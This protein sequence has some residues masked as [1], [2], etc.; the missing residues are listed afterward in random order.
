MDRRGESAGN[1][2]DPAPEKQHTGRKRPVRLCIKAQDVHGLPAG[3][4]GHDDD[5][6]AGRVRLCLLH[7]AVGRMSSVGGGDPVWDTGAV[8]DGGGH[9]SSGGTSGAGVC[10][11]VSLGGR[12]QSDALCPRNGTG[13]LR[14][15]W[16]TELS[17]KGAA[18]GGYHC[19]GS[20]RMRFG[21]LC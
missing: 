1:G 17:E 8:P 19:S 5:R 4:S 6:P 7:G 13:I 9:L 12:G 2:H 18:D 11:A 14:R 3:P 15:I 21:E 16:Q 10:G 20:D